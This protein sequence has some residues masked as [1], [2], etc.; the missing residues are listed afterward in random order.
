MTPDKS[1]GKLTIVPAETAAEREEFLRFPWRVYKGDPYW[2]PPLLSERREFLDPNKHPFHQHANVQ[3]F[4]ARRDG[5]IVGTIAAIANYRHNEYW[6]DEIGFFGLFEVGRDEEAARALLRTAEEALREAGFDTARGPM[7][8]SQNEECGLLIDGWNGSPVALMTYNPR[9]YVPFIEGAG[10]TK[11][12]DLYAFLADIRNIAPD[13]TGL[14]PKMLRVAERARKRADV[15]LRPI[16]MRDFGTDADHFKEVYNQAWSKNWGFVPLTNAELEHEVSSL[17]PIID[18]STVFFM[19]K[20]G[21]PVSAGLPLP[22]VNQAL[23]LA[24][25]RPN[26]PE[27]WTVLKFLYYLK[28]RKVVTTIRAFAGGVVEEYRGQG[29]HALMIVETMRRCVPRYKDVEFSWVLESNE[30]MLRT[31][32]HMNAKLYRTYRIYDKKL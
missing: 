18:P 15:T 2:V 20:D 5:E 13:G 28:I 27:W 4:T 23:H 32:E 11:A 24:Y 3:Y 26:V 12:Q 25:P 9:Y 22:D 30:P 6:N 17:K 14:N 29:L 1:L 8:F 16:N 19:F 21:H 7:N 10:Y 31:A